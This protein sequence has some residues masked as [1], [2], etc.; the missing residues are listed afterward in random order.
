MSP[1]H[2]IAPLEWVIPLD[3]HSTNFDLCC[4][5]QFHCFISECFLLFEKRG[6]VYHVNERFFVVFV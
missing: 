2:C 1:Y 6:R 4:R 3:N 5:L